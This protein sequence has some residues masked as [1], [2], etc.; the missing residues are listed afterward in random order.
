MANTEELLKQILL[1]LGSIEVMISE[2]APA[3]A[4]EVPK[5]KKKGPKKAPTGVNVY[6][7]TKKPELQA[8][9]PDKTGLQ[10]WTQAKKDFDALSVED[11]AKWDQEAL[12]ATSV[13]ITEASDAADEVV[14]EKVA[15]AAVVPAAAPKAAAPAVRRR[16]KA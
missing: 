14:A 7:K 12:D 3:A 2:K 8:A 13:T 5:K 1:R 6:F 9:H 10:L 11:K 15:P 4:A 16:T